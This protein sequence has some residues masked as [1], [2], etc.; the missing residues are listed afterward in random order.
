MVGQDKA[1]D[2]IVKSVRRNSVGIKELDKPIGSFICLGPTGVGKTHLAKKLAELMFGSE[3]SMI[4]VDMSE[5]QEKHSV[6]RLIGSPPGYVGY[7][8]GGQFTE[9]VRQNPYS[10]ILFDEIEKG[11]REIFNIL[12]QILDD[13]YVTDASGRKINFKNTLIMMTSN[14]GVKNSQDFSNGLGFTTKAS[15]QTDKERVRTIISKSLKNTFNPEFLNRLDDIII[16][17]TLDKTSIK[18]NSKN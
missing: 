10:L 16:F 18:K 3:E 14:I 6:S 13:G 17:E 8:E 1:I 4:R 15:Q 11:H 12:L 7:N 2:T 9:K 5:Y